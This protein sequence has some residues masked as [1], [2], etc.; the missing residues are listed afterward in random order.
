MYGIRNNFTTFLA[1]LP[2]QRSGLPARCIVIE[3]ARKDAFDVIT[4]PSINREVLSV[5]HRDYIYKKYHLNEKTIEAIASFLYEGTIMVSGELQI[6]K[7]KKDPDDNKF[8]SA[9]IEG[10]ANY[11]VSG[12]EHLLSLKKYKGIQIVTPAEFIEKIR[13]QT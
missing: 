11:I 9:A 3:M 2:D 1:F 8:L 4:S 5:L 12:D 13:P 6:T 10:K 7:I